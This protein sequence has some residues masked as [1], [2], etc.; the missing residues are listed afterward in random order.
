MKNSEETCLI[1]GPAGPAG[2]RAGSKD[3]LTALEPGRLKRADWVALPQKSVLTL[4]ARFPAMT[5]ERREAAAVLEL[6]GLGLGELAEEDYQ[7]TTHDSAEKDQR[8]MISVQ[9]A[10]QRV[11][12]EA[13]MDS[14]FAPSVQFKTLVPAE[15]NLWQE[16]G[17]WC[18]AV[19]D[20]HGNAL[21]AQALTA[22]STDEDAAAE[23]RCVLGALD[24]LGLAPELREA[25]VERATDEPPPL[26]LPEFAAEMD[27]PV[28][29]QAA[30]KPKLPIQTWRLAP[31]IVTQWRKE[32]RQR[33]TAFLGGL[34]A[35]LVLLA[36]LGAFTARLWTRERA[37]EQETTR[38]NQIEP[39]LATIRDAQ[40]RWS[41]IEPAI[42]P[43]RTPSEVFHQIARLM[44]E[45]GIRI[46]TFKL[47]GRNIIISAEAQDQTLEGQLRQNLLDSK[48]PAF[49]GL[50]WDTPNSRQQADGR[51]TFDWQA[52]PPVGADGEPVPST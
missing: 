46:S 2:W 45:K 28:S 5:E 17:Q 41:V 29:Q 3:G 33:Q 12:P 10:G 30:T 23:V 6:E 20:E 7:I 48:V 8:A 51:L 43:D 19:P 38:L 13:G 35:L 22:R 16:Q 32:R 42:A 1:P 44:P 15:V 31:P 4:P 40:Q 26:G 34:G 47:D 24:L 11:V 49:E 36:L 18:L 27:M 39:E 21:H 9:C 52:S 14:K 37:L 25:V 50:Q